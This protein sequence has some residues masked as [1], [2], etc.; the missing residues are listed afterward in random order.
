[1]KQYSNNPGI[2]LLRDLKGAMRLDRS[3]DTCVLVLTC[4]SYDFDALTPRC[5]EVVALIRRKCVYV[6]LQNDCCFRTLN[7]HQILSE[8]GKE[9]M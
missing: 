6:L 9:F 7:Q 8:I 5:V 3:K 2:I 1:V 4:A